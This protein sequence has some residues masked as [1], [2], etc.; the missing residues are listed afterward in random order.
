[1]LIAQQVVLIYFGFMIQ[2]FFAQVPGGSAFHY[3]DQQVRSFATTQLKRVLN[4]LLF[5]SLDLLLILLL[6]EF[7][8]VF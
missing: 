5:M 1:M 3:M 6:G 4:D 2:G 7:I 8:E